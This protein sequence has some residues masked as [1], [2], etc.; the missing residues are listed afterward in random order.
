[1]T[2][3]APGSPEETAIL[4]RVVAALEG[5][6]GID[7]IALGGSRATGAATSDS[8]F[9]I[10][11]YYRRSN[12]PDT[13]A[14]RMA[15]Q[16]LDDQHRVDAVTDLGG[17]G[18]WID[19]GGWLV[20]DELHIDFLYRDLDRVEAIRRDVETGRLEVAYQPG[21]PFG[22]V[23]SIYLA[24]A[25]TCRP[26]LDPGGSIATLKAALTPYPAALRRATIER[27]GWEVGFALEN[28]S[29]AATRGDVAYVSG[30]AFRAVT[31]MA[32]VLH[33]ANDE[34][35]LNEK[36]ALARTD[37]LPAHPRRFRRRAEAAI[38]RLSSDPAE[39]SSTLES[40][41]ALRVETL[42]LVDSRKLSSR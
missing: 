33:A 14:L 40:L 29:R 26:L 15:A 5:I 6:R 10:G 2:E 38:A 9:D 41:S 12:P 4:D 7:A 18:P 21:H 36:G 20:V 19:G 30:C 25:A 3:V 17:W 13:A 8:D 37:R 42:G 23:S 35:W 22:F 11:L 27:F 16:H 32:I 1:M 31:C 34:W 28:A 39:L 24:E